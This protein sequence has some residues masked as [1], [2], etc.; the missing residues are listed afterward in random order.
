ML[1]SSPKTFHVKK[2]DFFWLNFLVSDQLIWSRCCDADFNGVL[3]RLSCCLLKG[4]LKQDF[5]GIYITMFSESVISKI[6][7]LWGSFFFKRFEILTRFEKCSEKL[8]VFCL[9]DNCIWIGII[10]L[11]LLRTGYLS[12]A[13][14]VLTSSPN[15]WHV[16]KGDFFHLHGLSSDQWFL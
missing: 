7:K 11:S 14:N 12:S 9:W 4:S 13:A 1:T 8:R 10:K 2:R 15:V 6:Q 3:A 5:L 16:N